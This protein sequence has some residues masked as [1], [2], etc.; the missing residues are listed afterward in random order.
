MLLGHLQTV[1]TL[2]IPSMVLPVLS[3][4]SCQSPPAL[5]AAAFAS[6]ERKE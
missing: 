4:P 5:P 1:R 2:Q 3:S 6:G